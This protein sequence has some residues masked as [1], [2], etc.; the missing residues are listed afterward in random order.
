MVVHDAGQAETRDLVF[1]KRQNDRRRID[2]LFLDRSRIRSIEFRRE[3]ASR[4]RRDRERE[5]WRR[6]AESVSDRRERSVEEP[7]IRVG[8]E[9]GRGRKEGIHELQ[10]AIIGICPR[11]ITIHRGCTWLREWVAK[12]LYRVCNLSSMK[13]A[14]SSRRNLPLPSLQP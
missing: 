2:H 9:K 4:K 7:G 5:G 1:A 8:V 12:L 6:N 11:G 10:N 13:P 14:I 3:T